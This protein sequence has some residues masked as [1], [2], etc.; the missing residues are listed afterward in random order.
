MALLVAAWC[1][2]SSLCYI[3]DIDPWYKS[4]HLHDSMTTLQDPKLAGTKVHGVIGGCMVFIENVQIPIVD[5]IGRNILVYS[6]SVLEEWR[7]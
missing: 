1:S 2:L 6:Y 7:F 3:A 4:Q 5:D